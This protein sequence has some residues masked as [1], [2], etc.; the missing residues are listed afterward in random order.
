MTSISRR[1]TIAAACVLLP[2]GA[3]ACGD[4]D[5]EATSP[6]EAADAGIGGPETT[7]AEDA[8]AL[9]LADA[10]ARISAAGQTTGAAY[11]VITGGAAA[12]RLVAAAAPT[13]VAATTEIHEVVPAESSDTAEADMVGM[14]GAMTMR[15]V[16]ALDIPAGETV[17]LEPGGYHV[18]LL[19]LVAPLAAGD[20]FD[21]EL[22]FE[23]AGVMTVAVEVRDE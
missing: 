7:G 23:N 6:T 18:M 4:D 10:W 16:D 15:Q 2:L 20:T 1:A 9:T 11:L 8:A 22:T 12:D 17:T 3:V 19:D 21:L 5:D 14:D 13:T